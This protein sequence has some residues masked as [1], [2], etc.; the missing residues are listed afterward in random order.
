MKDELQGWPAI[1]LF[2]CIEFKCLDCL[3]NTRT[4]LIFDTRAVNFILS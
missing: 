1:R 2:R 3:V 4:Y